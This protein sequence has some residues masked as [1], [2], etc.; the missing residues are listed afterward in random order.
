MNSKPASFLEEQFV[1]LETISTY[2]IYLNAHFDDF[3]AKMR[4]IRN[5]ELE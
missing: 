3:S 1:P 4:K 2:T 5:Q